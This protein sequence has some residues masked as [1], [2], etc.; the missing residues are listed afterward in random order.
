MGADYVGQEKGIEELKRMSP[1]AREFLAHHLRNSL[2]AVLNGIEVGRADIVR[3]AGWHMV[4]DLKK[5]G[6]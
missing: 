3:E 6:C 2:N 5:I 4:E 1:E